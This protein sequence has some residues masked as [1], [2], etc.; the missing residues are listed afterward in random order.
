[1]WSVYRVEQPAGVAAGDGGVWLVWHRR[2]RRNPERLAQGGWTAEA[3]AQQREELDLGAL[4]LIRE[5]VEGGVVAAPG[6]VGAAH[7][8]YPARGLA[9]RERVMR[10]GVIGGEEAVG[11][12]EL[13]GGGEV[14]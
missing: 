14:G 2:V 1:M 6:I 5:C 3:F 4:S 11:S 10:A 13:G 9:A 12:P 8:P 7:Q